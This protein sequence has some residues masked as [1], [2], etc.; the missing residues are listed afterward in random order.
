MKIAA[1]LDFAL[2]CYTGTLKSTP[3][4][5]LYWQL[6][7]SL[8]AAHNLHTMEQIAATLIINLVVHP[9]ETI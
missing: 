8:R 1:D 6:T 2:P 9:I 7:N 5:K 4:Q 3:N